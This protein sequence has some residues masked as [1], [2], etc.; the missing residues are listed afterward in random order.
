[1]EECN[2]R[3]RVGRCFCKGSATWLVYK[4]NRKAHLTALSTL[5]RIPDPP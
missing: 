4:V 5:Q 2:G 3:W 1:V